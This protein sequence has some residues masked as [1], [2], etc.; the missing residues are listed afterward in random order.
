MGRLSVA[1]WNLSRKEVLRFSWH[2]PI[3]Y[4]KQVTTYLKAV[5]SLIVYILPYTTYTERLKKMGL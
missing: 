3:V 2:K 5:L 4:G 1:R